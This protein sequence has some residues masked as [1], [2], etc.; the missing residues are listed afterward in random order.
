[1]QVLPGGIGFWSSVLL[2]GVAVGLIG[3]IVEIFVLRPVYKAPE[4]FQL[5]ATWSQSSRP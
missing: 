5:V 3:V 4:L 1:M 2:A